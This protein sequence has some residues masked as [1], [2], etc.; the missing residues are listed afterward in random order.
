MILVDHLKWPEKQMASPVKWRPLAFLWT[1]S[2]LPGTPPVPSGHV[3]SPRP[4]T[5]LAGHIDSFC[6][7]GHGGEYIKWTWLKKQHVF[8][9]CI[10]MAEAH[11]CASRAY[12]SLLH[13]PSWH[14]QCESFEWQAVGWLRSSSYIKDDK[15]IE[16][17][18]PNMSLEYVV[19]VDP[20]DKT[21]NSIRERGPTQIIF[22]FFLAYPLL[23]HSHFV[24]VLLADDNLQSCYE[25]LLQAKYMAR[26]DVDSWYLDGRKNNLESW[27]WL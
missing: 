3:L 21:P 25:F 9:M 6:T 26:F 1:F 8:V 22:H 12:L 27:S 13:S 19:H 7:A 14:R 11:G 10:Y 18:V 24:G 23:I 5:H 17:E 16:V 2:T 20:W 15:L 4:S